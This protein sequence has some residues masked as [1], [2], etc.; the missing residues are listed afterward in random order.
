MKRS[1]VKSL[2]EY[3]EP[4]ELDEEKIIAAAKRL[5]KR[6]KL[7]TSVAL[8]EKTVK[9]LKIVADQKGVGYQVLMRMLI[10]DGLSRI[11]HIKYK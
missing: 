1:Y 6:R 11:K 5:K 9:E 10:I 7:P 3:D 4:V 2:K 8:E